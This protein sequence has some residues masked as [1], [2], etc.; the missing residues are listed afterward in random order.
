MITL[1][2]PS[3]TVCSDDAGVSITKTTLPPAPRQFPYPDPSTARYTYV[4]SLSLLCILRVYTTPD[5]L[6]LLGGLRLNYMTADDRGHFDLLRALIPGFRPAEY[7]STQLDP[8]LWATL[9]QIYDELPKCLR[10]YNIPLSDEHLPLLQ[11]VQS[12]PTF[13]LITVLNLAKC[14]V[15]T[16]NNVICLKPLTTLAALD[17]SYTSLSDYGVKSLAGTIVW[18]DEDQVYRGPSSL[19]VLKIRGCSKVTNSVYA[20]LLKLPLLCLVDLRNTLYTRADHSPFRLSQNSSLFDSVLPNILLTLSQ[21]GFFSSQNVYSIS[22]DRMEH[23]SA[24]GFA[25][26]VALPPNILAAKRIG[27]VWDESDSSSNSMNDGFESDEQIA[28]M[29][30]DEY[31]NESS[32]VERYALKLLEEEARLEAARD[33]AAS[34]YR[35][36]VDRKR[37]TSDPKCAASAAERRNECML[38]RQPPPWHFLNTSTTRALFSSTS[39]PSISTPS[40]HKD[41]DKPSGTKPAAINAKKAMK[42]KQALMDWDAQRRT[43]HSLRST[44]TR[45]EGSAAA[46]PSS[47]STSRNPFARRFGD[48]GDVSNPASGP[49]PSLLSVRPSSIFTSTRP[50]LGPNGA[51]D[52]SSKP[53]PLPPSNSNKTS[54]KK[55]S[56][57]KQLARP[58]GS[59]QSPSTAS[60]PSTPG[61][62]LKPVT[63]LS[64]PLPPSVNDVKPPSERN[65]CSGNSYPRYSQGA[66]VV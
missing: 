59:P 1:W 20:S 62:I 13:T 50:M 44:S 51:H 7:T 33:K 42:A 32:A 61:I 3:S 26:N 14:N 37:H 6:H 21:P 39:K 54:L 27:T 2:T 5:Q 56:S 41:H 18:S 16:D 34:F 10:T 15:L 22:V 58:S 30:E 31:D 52:T 64:V 29:P 17:A 35:R 55:A 8:R 11:Y 19:R 40:L 57:H 63:T 46:G 36:G 38:L 4:P 66:I 12:T 60:I 53:S 45:Q 25:R 49:H 47:A 28:D 43:L 24:S 48:D 23:P 65:G 9:I